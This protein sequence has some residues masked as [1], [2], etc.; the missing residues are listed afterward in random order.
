MKGFLAAHGFLHDDAV[1]DFQNQGDGYTGSDG[2]STMV[3]IEE[4]QES[5]PQSPRACGSDG[6]GAILDF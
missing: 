4:D 1:D 2:S 5:M 6:D 3:M